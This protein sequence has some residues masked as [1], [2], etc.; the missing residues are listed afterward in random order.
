[1][2]TKAAKK[3]PIFS[4]PEFQQTLSQI[5]SN[6]KITL[7]HKHFSEHLST[8]KYMPDISRRV[9]FF[10]IVANT[11]FIQELPRIMELPFELSGVRLQTGNCLLSNRLGVKCQVRNFMVFQSLTE[12]QIYLFGGILM[13]AVLFLGLTG[14]LIFLDKRG[15]KTRFTKPKS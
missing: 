5:T 9:R 2:T 8:A 7:R 15:S 1:M 12:Y 14:L 11:R 3:S 4:F 6:F 10:F 13:P